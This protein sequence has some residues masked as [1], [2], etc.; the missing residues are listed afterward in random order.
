MKSII[1]YMKAADECGVLVSA[2]FERKVYVW[3]TAARGLIS[4]C[5][6]D[7][8]AG[9]ERL[10]ISADGAHLYVGSYTSQSLDCFEVHSGKI[11]WR[12]QG[13]GEVQFVRFNS[14]TKSVQ[15][16]VEGPRTLVLN[17]FDGSTVEEYSK[18][19]WFVED[20]QLGARLHIGKPLQLHRRNQKS[21]NLSNE[22][23]AVLTADFGADS[24]AVSESGGAVRCHSIDDGR[25]IW[26]YVPRAGHHVL[27]LVY[28]RT[29]GKFY[30]VEWHYSSQP[31]EMN[32]L[33]I[34]DV[35][36]HVEMIREFSP[37]PAFVL[38]RFDELL[39]TYDGQG[40]DVRTGELAAK[41]PFEESIGR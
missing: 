20:Q 37:L 33:R 27:E 24:I 36:G 5:D 26:R 32:L 2:L 12:R 29:H 11:M 14:Y 23:F 34:D 7:L 19:E 28:M 8:D 6:T 13:I 21:M 16:G 15:C 9:G 40:F 22:S 4:I 41:L 10:A 35:T 39:W 3:D 31:A 38:S 1:R 17:A 18:T 25:E 30:A